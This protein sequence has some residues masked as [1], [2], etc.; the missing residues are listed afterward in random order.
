MIFGGVVMKAKSFYLS[1]LKNYVIPIA[2][3]V[4]VARMATT[5]VVSAAQVV[6]GSMIPTVQFPTYVVVDHLATEF[7]HPYRGEVVMFHRPDPSIPDDPLVKRIIGLPGDTVEVHDGH[8]YVNGQVLNEPYLKDVTDGTAGPFHVPAGHYF[9]MGDNR[10]ISFDSRFWK[11]KYVPEGNIIGRIDAV[12][13]PL[14]ELH[15]VQQ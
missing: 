5:W 1:L 12:M 4:G 7:S 3:G 10:N 6:S 9:M 15:A 13:W 8:V 2:I 11:V 14:S